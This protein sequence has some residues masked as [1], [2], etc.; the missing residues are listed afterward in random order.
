MELLRHI[1]EA[2]QMF[3]NGFEKGDVVCHLLKGLLLS[4]EETVSRET[5]VVYLEKHR[6]D[7]DRLFVHQLSMIP[8]TVIHYNAALLINEKKVDL[9]PSSQVK[10]VKEKDEEVNVSPTKKPNKK[11]SIFHSKRSTLSNEA[12]HRVYDTNGGVVE[13][14]K[15]FL[16]IECPNKKDGWLKLYPRSA[17]EN[18][19]LPL[20]TQ[21]SHTLT[22]INALYK[23]Q[24]QLSSHHLKERI[25]NEIVHTLDIPLLV[26]D[27][28]QD[29]LSK[30]HHFRC[31]YYNQ[32]FKLLVENKGIIGKESLLLESSPQDQRY[33]D[34]KHSI[35]FKFLRHPEIWK[36]I[37][38]LLHKHPLISAR[39]N[40][41]TRSSSGSFDQEKDHERENVSETIELHYFDDVFP[42]SDYEFHIYRVNGTRIGLVI[43]DVSERTRHLQL[44]EQASKA[45]TE[46]LANMNHEFRTPLNSIDGNLQLLNLT[47][48]LT[49]RQKELINRMRLAET[50]LMS[51]LQEVLDYAK[52]EQKKYVLNEENFSLRL[53]I[54]ESVDVMTAPAL[55]KHNKIIFHMA[56]DVPTVVYGDSWQLQKILVNLLSNAIRFTENGIIQINVSLMPLDDGTETL[57]FD[58]IDTGC[59]IDEETQRDLFKPWMQ[60]MNNRNGLQKGTG[61]GLAICKELCALMKGKIWLE[62]STLD[63]GSQFSFVLP[64]KSA[65][66]VDQLQLLS[67]EMSTLKG[68]KILLLH[69]SDE[70]RKKLVKTILSWGMLLTCANDS[71]E[72]QNFFEAGYAFDVVF[73]GVIEGSC[74][75]PKT[76]NTT[77]IL[78]LTHW[79]SERKA[80][81]PIILIGDDQ[82]E[83]DSTCNHLFRKIVQSPLNPEDVFHI[84][85][86]LFADH[87]HK[88]PERNDSGSSR[89][90]KRNKSCKCLIVEDVKENKQVLEDMLYHLGHLDCKSVENGLEM[91]EILEKEKDSFDV[92]FLDLLMPKMSGLEAIKE[93]RKTHP[94]NTRPYVIAVSATTL[95]KSENEQ[96]KSAGM[97]AFLQK[98]IKLNELKTLMD[99]ISR[100]MK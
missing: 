74:E 87:T 21:A 26:F 80:S 91:L 4:V 67:K 73:L 76:E 84:C 58:V 43:R 2:M 18:V 78:A 54:Q 66:S 37:D 22:A 90:E 46:F 12:L 6:K 62:S 38:R 49:E 3:N 55:V 70:T 9:I 5:V 42:E 28:T 41:I 75:H 72:A 10:E 85:V 64:F 89:P 35:F 24:H 93:L 98:P 33:E 31:A 69:P 97:D 60:S 77:N 79:L 19:G 14:F 61:L 68:K 1:A 32:S 45:K 20:L 25:F 63:H 86:N 30:E 100:K 88:K 83:M 17:F 50:A 39:N 34:D 48:P 27:V 44:I 51:L 36:A 11:W 65:E 40:P 57:R 95:L 82:S 59:G 99:I 52:L 7:N 13:K 8:P 81:F 56:L 23:K 53:C 94:M 29:D 92:I 47:Y 16:E 71:D 15:A 96:Y